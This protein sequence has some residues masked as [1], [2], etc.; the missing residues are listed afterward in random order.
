M[1]LLL[2]G[3]CRAGGVPASD[4]APRPTATSTTVPSATPTPTDYR[5]YTV[6]PGDTL[7]AI[8]AR[9]LGA[10]DLSTT[11]LDR[12]TRAPPPDRDRIN[13][14]QVLLL[15]VAPVAGDVAP[16][17]PSVTQDP[18]TNPARP[19]E[20][21]ELSDWI[22]GAE[23]LLAD[24]LIAIGSIVALIL[25]IILIRSRAWLVRG[26]T[27]TRAVILFLWT[28]ASWVVAAV[29]PWMTI[30]GHQIDVRIVAPGPVYENQ[31]ELIVQRRAA[32]GTW[33]EDRLIHVDMVA[34]PSDGRRWP[35]TR[36]MTVTVT[37]LNARPG[38]DVAVV[39]V[40]GRW[41]DDGSLELA[42][43]QRHS[44][45]IWSED[46]P[47]V[48]VVPPEQEEGAGRSA[49]LYACASGRAPAEQLPDAQPAP[50][51]SDA[52][53][54]SPAPRRPDSAA[55]PAPASDRVP[56]QAQVSAPAPPAQM[57]PSQGP[58]TGYA[59][60]ALPEEDDGAS[61]PPVD[62]VPPA[63]SIPPVDSVPP[64]RS[65]P[66]ADSIRDA[67]PYEVARPGAGRVA[68]APHHGRRLHRVDQTDAA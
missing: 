17:T 27:T 10:E 11:I 32:G 54:V 48:L 36:P 16:T 40:V 12:Q 56:T 31:M 64:A 43:R 47:G 51:R 28:A 7:R 5:A 44:N 20:L 29:R 63:R 59:S 21:P 30:R 3:G 46:L 8:A 14:G 50:N 49:R 4:T 68:H 41:L 45:G 37:A 42:L 57:P 1:V 33:R 65:I 19:A 67:Y 25:I 35:P 18:A 60:A 61:V 23:D 52:R 34:A 13:V 62:S 66:T 58:E 55:A 53:Q 6:R 24:L 22:G 15:P 26:V 39:R 2:L 38:R 9:E